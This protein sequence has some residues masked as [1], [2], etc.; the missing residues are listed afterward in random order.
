MERSNFE[1]DDVSGW[2]QNNLMGQERLRCLKCGAYLILV[3]SPSDG[4][5]PRMFQCFECD[6]PDPIKTDKALGWLKG[7]LQPPK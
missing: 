4:K 2:R 3:A 6:Q 5:G 1:M 7:E